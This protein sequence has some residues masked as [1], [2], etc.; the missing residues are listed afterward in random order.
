MRPRAVEVKP[1]EDY[2][3]EI[4]FDNG[5]K[6]FFDVKP[7]LEYVQFKQIKDEKIFKTVKIDGLSISWANGVDICPDELYNGIVTKN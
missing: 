2:L 5:E 4:T 7:Y 6:G 3:L 1:L